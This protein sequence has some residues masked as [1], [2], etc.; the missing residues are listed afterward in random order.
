MQGLTVWLARHGQSTSNAGQAAKGDSGI[1]LTELGIEQ[2][3]AIADEVRDRPS[4]LV[5]S[6]YLRARSTADAIAHRWPDATRET[7]AIQELT[8]LDPDRCLGTTVVT[9]QPLVKAY[10]DACDPDY[11]DGPG[12]ESFASF[13]TRVAA[14][15]DRLRA[16]PG[17]F[18]VV[19]GHGQFFAAYRFALDNGFEASPDW[20]RRYRVFETASP[21]RNGEIVK[22]RLA[23]GVPYMQ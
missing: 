14:F 4:L 19:V 11:V 8:Y 6:P 12:A 2:A 13:V 1:A 15:H 20:M 9:R 18:V 5:D 22:L 10:W 17:G 21:M 7:W 16:L 23:E 3:R